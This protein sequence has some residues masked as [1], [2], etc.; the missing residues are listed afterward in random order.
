MSKRSDEEYEN[1]LFRL[2]EMEG[3]SERGVTVAYVRL[4]FHGRL[5]PAI[6]LDRDTTLPQI[7]KVWR[8]FVCR[9]RDI[10]YARQPYELKWPESLYE[11]ICAQLETEWVDVKKRRK[12]TRKT[13]RADVA[14]GYNRLVKT[15]LVAHVKDGAKLR[16]NRNAYLVDDIRRVSGRR[17]AAKLAAKLKENKE[18][19][20]LESAKR[21]L[22]AFNVKDVDEFLQ[23]ALHDIRDGLPPVEREYPIDRWKVRYVAS[24]WKKKRKRLDAVQKHG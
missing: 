21:I 8:P 9:Y 16:E 19:A 2:L 24:A 17:A 6:I 12:V 20:Y 22:E 10:L 3:M 14:E 7:E 1:L 4:P 23:G 11:D 18:D 5:R 15:Y 13:S